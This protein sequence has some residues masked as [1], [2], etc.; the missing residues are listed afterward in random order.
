MEKYGERYISPRFTREAFIDI[1]L[2]VTSDTEDWD[3]ALR[4]LD[5][6]II[7]RYLNPIF[8]LMENINQNGFAIMALNCFLVETFYQF[9]RGIYETE[10]GKNRIRYVEFL[11]RAM[12]G[13]FPS[14]K[15]REKFYTDIRCGILHSAQT[16]NG[17]QLTFDKPYVV[18]M[19]G[20]NQI[21]I[22]VEG[23]TKK[24]VDYY[25]L[26]LDQLRNPENILLRLAFIN[27]MSL[28]CMADE[29]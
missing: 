9:E 25:E 15:S 4:I 20:H 13:V 8:S 7:G 1:H 23:F 17:S 14:K 10:P 18:K 21:S 19:F 5:D 6:R 24:L 11:D 3:W 29:I 12:P 27:K 28:I 22:D 26:Y 16:K 2:S